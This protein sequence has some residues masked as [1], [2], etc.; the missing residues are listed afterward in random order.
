VGPQSL[1]G[2]QLAVRA[3]AGASIAFAVA[4]L[5]NLDH[6]IIAF[7]AAVIVT[8]LKPAQT[9][10]LGVRRLVA[11]LVG[12]VTG[13]VLGTILQPRAWAIGLSVLV[14]I[15]ISHMLRARE[16]AKVAGYICG[17]I[18]LDHSA[19]PWKD[20]LA[21]TFETGLGVSVAWLISYVPKL[22]AVEEQSSEE[23]KA[24][25]ASHAQQ[26]LP[27]QPPAT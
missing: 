2:V 3:A 20:A 27:P 14:A 8:D 6:P 1:R 9:R 10:E 4:E 23:A 22:I 17:L 16:G 21:R 12:G 19:E 26:A 13:A 15:L 18:V 24:P 5:L 7:T 11:T 25:E